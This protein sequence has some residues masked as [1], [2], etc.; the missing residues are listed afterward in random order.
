MGFSKRL[1]KHLLER[2]EPTNRRW[3]GLLSGDLRELPSTF[4]LEEPHLPD[5]DLPADLLR[6]FHFMLGAIGNCTFLYGESRQHHTSNM[7]DVILKL[8]TWL[9]RQKSPSGRPTLL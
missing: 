4:V 1:L 8:V 7:V 5:N 6:H 9:E 2:G 3:H